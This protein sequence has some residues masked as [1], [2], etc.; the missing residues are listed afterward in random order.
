MEF[1][2]I[3]REP[4]DPTSQGKSPSHSH[5]HG[6]V[7]SEVAN[8]HGRIHHAR[9]YLSTNHRVT[10]NHGLVLRGYSDSQRCLHEHGEFT[11]KKH[12]QESSGRDGR[13]GKNCPESHAGLG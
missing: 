3:A 10:L 11:E 5:Q 13:I 2:W 6:H 1:H 9:S 7:Q 8:V 12:S 4:I